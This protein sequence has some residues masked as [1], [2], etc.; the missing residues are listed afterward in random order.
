[1]D[2]RG[3]QF[4]V[5]LL[6]VA[7]III[8][9]ILVE[10]LGEM[11]GIAKN[12]Y[13]IYVRFPQAPG[14]AVNTPVL[15]SGILVGRVSRVTLL[16]D[17]GVVVTA[18]IDSNRQLKNNEICRISS[19]SILGDAILEFVPNNT[20]PT[21][22]EI[23]RDGEYLDGIVSQDPLR[24]MESAT[25][26]LDMLSTL[27]EEVR[28]ALISIEGAG[29]R[30]GN[31]ANSMTAIIDNNQDQLR[32]VLARAE[33]A[34]TRFDQTIGT[35]GQLAMSVDRIIGSE[36][37]QIAVEKSMNE[38]P[39]LFTDARQVLGNIH[40][41]SMRADRN[42]RNLEG[43]T[44]P[45]GRRGPE[46]AGAIDDA[47]A[48]VRVV[49]NQLGTFTKSV[50]NRQGTVGHLIHDR[51]LYDQISSTVKTINST[52]QHVNNT[53]ENVEHISKRARP[54]VEDVRVFSDKIARDPGRLGAKGMLDRRQSG[55]KR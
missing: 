47:L 44:G 54:I 32:R 20:T 25:T 28:L 18:R 22:T 35:V 31:V 17:G 12:Q 30:V 33:S 1:M 39:K 23:Y 14:V 49:L 3:L 21:T 51:E 48:E 2:D 46:Y 36:D 50:N 13:T 34:M 4:R 6:V 5:G 37:V 9:V 27:E 29:E 42:L 7:T 38:I 11:P 40:E 53:V 26:V 15:K 43:L 8:A 55:T 19:G 41:V 10:R 24:V 52:V 45:L 16:D